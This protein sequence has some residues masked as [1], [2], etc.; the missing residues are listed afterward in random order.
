MSST[1]PSERNMTV[2]GD[3]E[4]YLR[5]RLIYRIEHWIF[6]SSFLI[7]GL[8]GLVQKFAESPISITIVRAFGG[9][10]NTRVIHHTAAIVMMLV[11]IYHI[12]A[13]AYRVY[14]KRS[15]LTMLPGVEDIRAAVGWLAYN[16]GFSKT[17]PQEG[18]YTFA[19]KLEYWAVVWGTIVMAI[20]GFMMWN[21]I[22]TTR[23]LP[24]EWI[25][26]AK[27]AHGWEAVLAVLAIFLW[28]FYHVFFRNFNKSMY[29]G[30]IDQEEMLED[31]ALELADIKAGL[32]ETPVDAKV[33]VKRERIFWPTYGILAAVMLVGVYLFVNYEETAIATVPP[34]EEVVVFV[35]L[36]PTP[37][38]TPLPSPTP[39]P[40]G[41]GT[42]W[43]G[44]LGELFEGKCG[45]CHNSSSKLGGLDLSSYQ[46][47]LS[48]GN[49]GQGIVPGDP[50][51]SQVL[52]I[53]S[54]GGHPGQ[55][56]TDE[57]DTV[58]QWIEA[59]APEN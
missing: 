38:P 58:I 55:L 28:H 26:A 33:K 10:E 37:L 47:A 19:E 14:V 45:S 11:T 59:G 42:S 20:T 3:H 8:T 53:Q 51:S 39:L 36:T 41:A 54:A 32:A 49:S 23:F 34:A 4:R 21:P 48:G 56:S 2:S 17:Q 35:P 31:H 5:F 30:Y 57:L 50:T 52:I 25:P 18:R 44:G 40:V 13:A 6:I 29:T 9:I 43:E 15:Q 12:G 27:A 22:S 1:T 16:L 24:G 7:L 46:A